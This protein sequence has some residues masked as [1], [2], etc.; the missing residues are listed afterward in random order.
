MIE[1]SAGDPIDPGAVGHLLG[2]DREAQL[3]LQ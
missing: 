3:L 1:Q 2:H